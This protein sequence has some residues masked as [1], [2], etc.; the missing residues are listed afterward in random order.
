MNTI[1][2]QELPLLSLFR[3]VF[4]A[5]TFIRAQLLAVAAILTQGRRTLANLLRTVGHQPGP[6]IQLS[7]VQYLIVSQVKDRPTNQ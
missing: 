3:P 7:D 1:A 2:N 5:A 4:T 6:I